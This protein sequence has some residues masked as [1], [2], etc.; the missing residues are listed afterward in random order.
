MHWSA[1]D[2]CNAA[3]PP[4]AGVASAPSPTAAAA[5]TAPDELTALDAFIAARAWLDADALP[6]LDAQSA[7]VELRDTAGVCVL[8]RLDGRVV[9]VGDDSLGDPLMLRR[10]VGRAVTKALGD[11]TIRAVR[12]T[13]GD[14]VTGRLSLEVELAGALVPLLGRTIADAAARVVPGTDGL[15]VRRGDAV[16]RAYPSRLLSAD[17]A[18]RPD[19]TITALMVDAGLPAKDL[20][21]FEAADR[22]SLARFATIRLR[23]AKTGAAPSVITRAGRPIEFAEVTPAFTRSL[24]AQL[25]AR[26]S[27]QVVPRSLAGTPEQMPGQ[28]ADVI[29]LLGKLNPTADIYEPPFADARDSAF[30]ALA[31]AEAS[32]S[33]AIP[34]ALRDLARTNALALLRSVAATPDATRPADADALSALAFAASGSDDAVLRAKLTERARA[35]AAKF[36]KVEK[37]DPPTPEAPALAA[38]GFAAIAPDEGATTADRIVGELFTAYAERPGWL[39]EAAIP[40]AYLSRGGNLSPD[41]AAQLR[42]LFTKLAQQLAA[43]QIGAD[44]VASEGIPADVEGGLLMPGVLRL[45]PD[46]GC[47]RYAAAFAIAFPP[48]DAATPEA[49]RTMTR[50]FVRFL[51]QHVADE[52]WVDGF[53]DPKALRGL[54]RWSLAGDDCPP[55]ATSAGLLLSTAAAA[56]S[57]Q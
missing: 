41:R 39:V 34:D 2:C 22:V 38:A 48:A 20:N 24:A 8:L 50:R 18:A 7:Q 11:D 43:E 13:M 37:T 14:K 21:K 25:S 23:Q 55:T 12:A 40:L 30:A 5:N 4:A 44:P 47:L 56:A 54:V 17:I 26:L 51:A 42:T 53:R 28:M 6:A 16:F 15:A 46:C 49:V 10:A 57:A 32:R 9:G 19:G 45:R 52:P 27:G 33:A 3:T 35:A 1:T 31:L 36:A 29:G